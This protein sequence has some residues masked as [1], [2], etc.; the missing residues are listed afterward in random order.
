MRKR[1]ADIS[2][3]VLA[4]RDLTRSDESIQQILICRV[5]RKEVQKHSRKESILNLEAPIL[6]G[7]ASMA[8]LRCPLPERNHRF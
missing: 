5:Q 8:K 4:M 2:G 7:E 3:A 6:T 1:T